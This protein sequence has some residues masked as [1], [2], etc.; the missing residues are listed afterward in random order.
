MS[1]TKK[2]FTKHT[3]P[4]AQG[5]V[6]GQLTGGSRKYLTMCTLCFWWRF[7]LQCFIKSFKAMLLRIGSHLFSTWHYIDNDCICTTG[8]VI[9]LNSIYTYK[10][11]SYI[12][13][14]RLFDVH[15]EKGYVY[16]SLYFFSKDEIITVCQTLNQ[17]SYIIWRLMDKNEYDELL[18][19]RIRCKVTRPDDLLDFDFG[20]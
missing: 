10:E 6:P 14:V 20:S 7:Y 5:R 1:G 8:K 12:D 13:I 16:C 11:N 15:F 3:Q 2:H 18:S 17:D 4:V 19:R 9:K